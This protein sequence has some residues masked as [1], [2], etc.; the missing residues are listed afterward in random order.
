MKSIDNAN[1]GFIKLISPLLSR[2][3]IYLL[4]MTAGSFKAVFYFELGYG[5]LKLDL[6][7]VMLFMLSGRFS[8]DIFYREYNLKNWSFLA[9]RL[10]FSKFHFAL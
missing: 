4:S 5:K 3:Q 7:K 10:P 2:L 6:Q 8:L 9:S 1:S